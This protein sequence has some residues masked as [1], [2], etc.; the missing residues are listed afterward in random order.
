MPAK[1]SASFPIRMPAELESQ[2]EH[3]VALTGLSKQDV[4]RLCIRIGLE[5]LRRCNF[6]LARAIVE[7]P[8]SK[9]KTASRRL[10]RMEPALTAWLQVGERSGAEVWPKNGARL[11]CAAQVRAGY[12]GRWGQ[13]PDGLPWP[14]NALRHSFASYHLAHFRDSARTALEL[15]HMDTRILFAHYREMVS[16]EAAADFWALRP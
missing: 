1:K 8:A 5:D 14:D 13:N 3:A 2:L 7:V 12:R 10:V 6:D 16:P 15:G 11:W 9:S 4:I